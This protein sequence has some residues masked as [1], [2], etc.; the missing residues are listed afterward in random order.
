M[1]KQI[2][3]DDYVNEWLVAVNPMSN[4]Y[5]PL[6]NGGNQEFLVKAS[7]PEPATMLLV[8]FGIAGLAGYAEEKKLINFPVNRKYEA[9]LNSSAFLLW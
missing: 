5:N 6:G 8:G 2:I 9:E 7:V 3:R 1:T 4:E